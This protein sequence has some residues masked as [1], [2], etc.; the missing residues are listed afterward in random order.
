[1]KKT[2]HT[3]NDDRQNQPLTPAGDVME[4]ALT[5]LAPVLEYL[6]RTSQYLPP[7]VH[8]RLTA[9]R[10]KALAAIDS[11]PGQRCWWLL[12]WVTPALAAGA[13]F[14][15]MLPGL[16]GNWSL[17]HD[18]PSELGPE[19]MA[20]PALTAEELAGLNESEQLDVLENMEF[21]L[22][23]DSQLPDDNAPKH[24]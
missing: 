24:S 11:H 22:W 3:T 15:F 1:M 18:G 9:H 7:A 5:D 19:I 21:Y 16:F 6:E 8:Q 23:L 13:L 17:P 20:E 2:P 14:L 4:P 12:W 10:R